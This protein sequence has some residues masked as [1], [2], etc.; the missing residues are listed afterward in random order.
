MLSLWIKSK[1]TNTEMWQLLHK[2]IGAFLSKKD[3][4][5]QLQIKILPLTVVLKDFMY[6]FERL[7]RTEERNAYV[8]CNHGW[9]SNINIRICAAVP[10]PRED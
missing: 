9:D 10:M 5:A 3:T 2:T 6:T 8:H 4:V 7:K 1:T